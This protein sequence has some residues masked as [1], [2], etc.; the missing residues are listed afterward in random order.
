MKACEEKKN[1]SITNII[2]IAVYIILSVS[3][4]VLFKLGSSKDFALSLGNGSFS[5]SINLVAI[6]GLFCYIC[7]F[8]L[9]MFLVSKFD[10]SYIVPITQGII[11][12]LIFASSIGVF[13]EKITT[14]GIIGTVMVIL[15]IILLNI[16]K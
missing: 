10:L 9:Y 8:L 7:S 11:Y 1:M 15:G 12:V 14:T 2:L 5:M 4:L 6:L 13:K 3:G 16:K